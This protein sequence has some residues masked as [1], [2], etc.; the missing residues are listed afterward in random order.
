MSMEIAPEGSE[1]TVR[2]PMPNEEI[3]D[4]DDFEPMS[5]GFQCWHCQ[6][7]NRVTLAKFIIKGFAVCE[8][9]ANWLSSSEVN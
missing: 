5:M 2:V 7:E 1:W 3:Q 9:H 6:I 4:V 8:E